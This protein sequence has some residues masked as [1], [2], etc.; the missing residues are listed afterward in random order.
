[1]AALTRITSKF[2][3]ETFALSLRACIKPEWR[4]LAGWQGGGVPAENFIP[5]V[6]RSLELPTRG[7]GVLSWVT[8]VEGSGRSSVR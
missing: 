2:L 1:M 3:A 4:R 8:T 5:P 7:D 6:R